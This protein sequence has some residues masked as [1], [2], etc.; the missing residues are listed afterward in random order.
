M[1]G[2]GNVAE[3]RPLEAPGVPHADDCRPADATFALNDATATPL[4]VA[5]LS[6]S[7][8]PS[9][10]TAEDTAT[11]AG[12]SSEA[13]AAASDCANDLAT[14]TTLDAEGGVV[15]APSADVPTFDISSLEL[16]AVGNEV[17]VQQ[18]VHSNCKSLASDHPCMMNPA[19]TVRPLSSTP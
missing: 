10:P 12:L 14:T 7:R 5:A 15:G 17:E 1:E 19:S 9:A 18:T 13:I 4:N 2:E 11:P 16:P 3:I 8:Y 6:P